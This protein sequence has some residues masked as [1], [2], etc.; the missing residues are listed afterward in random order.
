MS[1]NSLRPAVAR[2]LPHAGVRATSSPTTNVPQPIR[3]RRVQAISKRAP[4]SRSRTNPSPSPIARPVLVI[5]TGV[6]SMRGSKDLLA[7]RRPARTTTAGTSTRHSAGPNRASRRRKITSPTGNATIMHMTIASVAVCAE[8]PRRI[9][10]PITKVHPNAHTSP[11]GQTHQ[12]ARAITARPSDTRRSV[13]SPSDRDAPW[14]KTL[15]PSATVA[16]IV[17]GNRPYEHA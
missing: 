11:Y 4:M 8:S 6:V 10:R 7:F 16:V 9:I 14:A 1:S 15:R 2:S 3:P 13:N 5:N 12:T 17:F